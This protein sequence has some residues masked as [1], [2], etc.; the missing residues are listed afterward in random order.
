MMLYKKT[1]FFACIVSP[2]LTAQE[3]P[4]LETV[5][6]AVHKAFPFDTALHLQEYLATS[7]TGNASVTNDLF[8]QAV[9]EAYALLETHKG[10]IALQQLVQWVNVLVGYKATTEA[11][12]RMPATPLCAFATN[13]VT[14]AAEVMVSHVTPFAVQHN[15]TGVPTTIETITGATY[16]LSAKST[17]SL[18]ITAGGIPTIQLADIYAYAINN[19][20][21]P[22]QSA[23]DKGYGTTLVTYGAPNAVAIRLSAPSGKPFRATDGNLYPIVTLMPQTGTMADVLISLGTYLNI[24]I[25]SLADSTLLYSTN[26]SHL[27]N[28]T[29]TL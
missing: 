22:S 8:T 4:L 2:L 21:A 3:V 12:H 17:S 16:N 27:F 20:A 19:I 26:A 23:I 18:N 10:D 9:D 6:H 11:M 15:L 14:A 25:T 1:I 28:I 5:L 13:G 24:H 7:D 29:Y